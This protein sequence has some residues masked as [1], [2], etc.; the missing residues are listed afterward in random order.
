[1]TLEHW[2]TLNFLLLINHGSY[3]WVLSIEEIELN[4]AQCCAVFEPYFESY[5][6]FLQVDIIAKDANNLLAWKGWIES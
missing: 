5:N 1:M 2:I 3:M 4:K 6:N